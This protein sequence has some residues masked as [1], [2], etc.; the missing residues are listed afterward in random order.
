MWCRTGMTDQV[1]GEAHWDCP[2]ICSDRVKVTKAHVRVTVIWGCTRYRLLIEHLL[3]VRALYVYQGPA[4]RAL[5]FL[6]RPVPCSQAAGQGELG[7]GLLRLSV[8]LESI[9][10]IRKGMQETPHTACFFP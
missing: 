9:S 1:Q 5:Q 2:I 10:C 3:R 7:K 6:G 8:G 4:L